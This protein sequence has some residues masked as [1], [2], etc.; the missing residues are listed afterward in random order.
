MSVTMSQFLRNALYADALVSGAAAI[1]MVAGAL[2][3]SPLL[4]LPNA[5]L[6]G[7]GLALVPF[8]VLLVVVARRQQVSR[9][10]LI[11]IIAIN[12]LWVAASFGLLASGL[13]A[14]NALGVAF[15]AVQAVTVA[16]LAE[17]QFVGLRRSA[18]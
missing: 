16:L 15:V 5:L 8:V 6:V 1:L 13:V 10:V 17:T 18:A 14:P 3:L 2:V 12:A 7:A 4:G 11:D 9:M